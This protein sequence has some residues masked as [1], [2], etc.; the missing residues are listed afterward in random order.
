MYVLCPL[1]PFSTFFGDATGTLTKAMEG[2][3]FDFA[4]N[5]SIAQA[6]STYDAV[7][8]DR[9]ISASKGVFRLNYTFGVEN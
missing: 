6:A 3:Q 8:L 4:D 1:S 9:F 2:D 5:D 7:T